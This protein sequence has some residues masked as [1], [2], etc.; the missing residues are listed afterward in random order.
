MSH[1]PRVCFERTAPFL[2]SKYPRAGTFESD[3]SNQ[4]LERSVYEIFD[5]KCMY[6][7][8]VGVPVIKLT[9]EKNRV[10]QNVYKNVNFGIE[11]L[12]NDF[13]IQLQMTKDEQRWTT[14]TDRVEVGVIV[15]SVISIIR[16][17]CGH[18]KRNRDRQ[19]DIQ[20][21][22]CHNQIC[23]KRGGGSA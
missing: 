19:S 12:S 16:F 9:G 23:H 3:I 5:S 6:R 13:P 7:A 15:I 2:Y 21:L 14:E 18:E 11:A 20:R 1:V 10:A 4:E 17:N 8:L 22:R